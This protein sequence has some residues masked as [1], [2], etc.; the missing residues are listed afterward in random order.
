MEDNVEKIS[1]KDVSVKWG[2]ISGIV[3]ILFSLILILGDL[4]LTPGVSYI[5]LI[6]FAIVLYMAFK[7]FK[8]QGDSFMTL[9]QSLKI[10]LMISL[11]GGLLLSVFSYI[12]G[13]FI[14]PGMADRIKDML[15]EQWEAQG[16]SDEQIDQAMKFTSYMFNPVIGLI[17]VLLKNVLVGFVLSLI[18][19]AI[20]KK[21]NPELEV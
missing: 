15:I 11:I 7:E 9:G 21:N 8:D 1:I 19:G 12:Y 17:V 6:P 10:G 13:Q 2:L 3:G 20:T 14:D 4:M 18:I 16:M 5:G